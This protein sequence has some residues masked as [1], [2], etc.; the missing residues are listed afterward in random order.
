MRGLSYEQMSEQFGCSKKSVDNALSRCRR[1]MDAGG[2][3]YCPWADALLVIAP[4]SEEVP[5]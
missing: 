1:V 2:Y 4:P 3:P 5:A